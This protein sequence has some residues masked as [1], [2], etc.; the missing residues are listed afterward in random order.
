[1]NVRAPAL[2]AALLGGLPLLAA[3]GGL[4]ETKEVAQTVY[5]LR[6]TSAPALAPAVAGEIVVLR[7]L[8][9]PGL[10]T[11]RIVVTLPDRRL[12]GYRGS[13]WSAPAPDLVQSL[14]LDGLRAR[15][16]WQ[17]VL[18]DRGEFRGRYALQTEIRDFQ[19]EYAEEGA[20]PT[21]RVT[22]RGDLGRAPER[23]PIVSA[24]GT[25]EAR[26]AS[27]RM[28]DVAAAFESAYANAANQV[29]DAV[30][31]GALAAAGRPTEAKPVTPAPA[32][33][34]AAPAAP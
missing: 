17:T 28:R 20:A 34:T 1:M 27:N 13:H 18:P 29:I 19:A 26:A 6:A 30:H 16:A 31:A 14:L 11:D 3:C 22:L 10:D 15:G 8:A 24:V 4:L 7:P 25:G 33:H 9:R 23:A 21:V 5:E 12:D 2:A 32:T